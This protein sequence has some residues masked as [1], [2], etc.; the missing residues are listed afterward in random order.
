[1]PTIAE[2]E[3]P[4]PGRPPG[5]RTYIPVANAKVT[6]IVSSRKLKLSRTFKPM[7]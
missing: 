3:A 2:A 5:P 6:P 4:P 7:D 1:M